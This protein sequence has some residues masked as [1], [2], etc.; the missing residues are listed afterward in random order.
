[1]Y[2]RRNKRSVVSSKI[3]KRVQQ[4]E[5]R[6]IQVPVSERGLWPKKFGS[7]VQYSP[8]QPNTRMQQPVND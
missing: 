3:L 5:E 7:N 4:N 2:K 1:L 8:M 6:N